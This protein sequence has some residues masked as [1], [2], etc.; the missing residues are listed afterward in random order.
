M[1]EVAIVA[2]LPR[3]LLALAG[4]AKPDKALR[5]EGIYLVRVPGGVLAAA[6]MGAARVTLAVEAALRAAPGVD[7][8]LSAG[9][10]G[11]CSGQLQPGQIAEAALVVD[12]RTGERYSTGCEG[13][14]LVSFDAIASVKEKA[15]LAAAYGAALVDMEAATVARLAL[16]RGL[17]FRAVKGVSD[18]HDFELEG[19]SRFSGKR[20]EFRTAAFALHTALRPWMWGPAMTLGRHS[21]R[22][23]AGLT[24]ALR[25]VLVDASVR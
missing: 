7:T 1:G 16:A 23:L 25:Q 13:E 5:R 21:T 10:A 11:A 6:G 17:G 8:L 20:G 9:L 3:E 19:L 4:E 15:R 22:A 18:A 2:A 12:A 24:E 14:V